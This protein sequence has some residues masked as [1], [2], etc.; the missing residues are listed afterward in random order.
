MPKKD[1]TQIALDVVR[2]ATGEA[3][4]P[5]P[6]KKQ[7]AARA[8][9]S[10]GGKAR[11]AAMTDDER[12]ALAMQGVAGKKKAPARVAGAHDQLNKTS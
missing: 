3:T 1:F 2:R 12:T 10:K 6:S 11:Q 5:A 7:L 9:G 4:A 8:K